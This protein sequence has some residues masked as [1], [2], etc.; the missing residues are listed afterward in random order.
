MTETTV[1]WSPQR[2]T[3][4]LLIA[5]LAVVG[6]SSAVRT[7]VH[8]TGHD[9]I[10]GL[11]P[12]F[13][14][15]AEQNIPTLFS[16]GLLLLAAVHLALISQLERARGSKWGRYWQ[17]LGLGFALI[18]ADEFISLHEKLTGPIRAMAAGAA[19]NAFHY[20]WVAV[21]LPI[22]LVVGMVFWLFLVALPSETRRRFVVA[23]ALYVGGAL[24]LEVLGG[25]VAA[26]WGVMSVTHSVLATLEEAMEML[27]TILFIR[28]LMLYA[29]REFG[30]IRLY[31][32]EG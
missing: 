4:A 2:I 28:A 7:V 27:G 5:M 32:A 30:G 26:S 16:V 13:Y 25:M 17:L 1:T 8:V 3:R 31:S 14:V 12:L 20:G 6:L 19:G 22:V 18:A 9:Y 29:Q 10:M 21:G 23:G 15:D 11:V 24:F